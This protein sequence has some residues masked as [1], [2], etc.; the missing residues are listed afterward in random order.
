MGLVGMTFVNLI[1][2]QDSVK[3]SYKAA[4]VYEFFLL[5]LYRNL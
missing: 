3:V 4:S 2:K 1:K 5:C